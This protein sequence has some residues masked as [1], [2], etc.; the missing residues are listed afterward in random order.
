MSKVK[1]DKK[2]L[3]FK[4]WTYFI[5][6]A[7]T[8]M[9]ILW[10]LQ[11]VFI[12]SFYEYMKINEIKKIGD[13]LVSQY[14]SV[15][16]EEILIEKSFSEGISINILDES[17]RLIYPLEFFD[18]IR[19]PR[20]ETNTFS[21]LLTR[22]YKSE[23]NTTIYT[24]DDSRLKFPVLTY[25]AILE[26]PQSTNYFLYINTV[27]EPIDS[28]VSVL[29]N[30]LIIITILSLLLAV[31]LSFLISKK[32]SKPIVDITQSA[33]NLMRG[34]YNIEFKKGYYTEI[35]NLADTLND[36]TA[37][38]SKTEDLRQDLISNITH[39]LKTPLTL[40]KSYGELIRD[41]SGDDKEKRDYHL[42]I[43]IQE[44]DKLSHF[45]DDMLDLSRVQS[46]L[47]SLEIKEIDL[48][49]C[50]QKVINRF[51]YYIE[52]EEFQFS[53]SSKGF[54]KIL[55]DESKIEQAIYNLVSNG[56]NY[57]KDN[58]KILISV[59]GSD[60]WVRLAVKDYGEG[61][62]EE[63]LNRIWDRYYRGGKLH[64][65]GKTGTGIGLSIVKSIV[66]AHEG[67]Y[68]VESVL[69]EGSTFIL[70]FKRA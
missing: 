62:A 20:L 51:N 19:Q 55:G 68:G 56:I 14:G 65:R 7:S 58:K 57:S 38:L 21:E 54:T 67:K 9:I 3:N 50:S 10:L 66:I 45:V 34:N 13:Q 37:E 30:Q 11:I 70:E 15:D 52:Q 17:G 53:I 69:G 63:D 33:K 42:D 48:L 44:T 49:E 47:K 46:G 27:I 28:T 4:L 8:I 41:I 26:N 25:G 23:N 31:G 40:I 36:T 12:N 6:F 29:K 32:L 24:R 5:G 43:I 60:Q 16:F 64:K 61:I 35:D 18:I 2:T 59:E 22:L 1:L 39:D